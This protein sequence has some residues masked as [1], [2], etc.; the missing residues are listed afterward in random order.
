M[1]GGNDTAVRTRGV[2][3]EYLAD[4]YWRFDGGGLNLFHD[5]K[6]AVFGDGRVRSNANQRKV[7]VFH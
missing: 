1:T 7:P 3:D 6:D 5:L 2:F 4:G